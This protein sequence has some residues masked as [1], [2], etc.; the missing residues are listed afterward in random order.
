MSDGYAHTSNI[1][2]LLEESNYQI[3]DNP[4]LIPP[5]FVGEIMVHCNSFYLE[6][7]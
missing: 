4:E 6:D 2:P 1:I 5:D 3:T 7:L